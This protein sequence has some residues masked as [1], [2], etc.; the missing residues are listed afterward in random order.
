M[1]NFIVIS[2]LILVGAFSGCSK[3]ESRLDEVI[4]VRHRGADMPA[5]VHGNAEDKVFI[6]V[7]HG[8]G[9]FGLAF[10]D[11]AIKDVLEEAYV[12]VYWD[13]RG[14]GMSQGR[15]PKPDDLVSLMADDVIALAEVLRAKYGQDI[16]LFLMG[17]SWGGALGT[18]ALLKEDRQNLF[19]GWIAVDG[20]H[21]F[22]LAA[23]S[24]RGQMLS[25]AQEQIALGNYTDKWQ[26][27]HDGVS[28]L[29]SLSSDDYYPTLAFA[30]K[31][32]KLLYETGV[33]EHSLSSEK[34][35]RTIIDNN[36]VTWMTSNLLN[37]PVND[38]LAED[39]SLS[40][41]LTEITLPVLLIYGKYD[42][43]VPP[44]MGR[45]AYERLGSAEKELMIFEHSIHHPHDTEPDRFT[46][47]V[48]RFVEKYR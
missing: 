27:L 31:T 6:V 32:M 16:Q 28:E 44:V 41:R 1:R 34:V 37:Q 48:V 36:P 4:H 21:D 10:R 46:D 26:E 13:Q 20:V 39:Y 40:D 15:Y 30:A 35:Y 45:D 33:I 11:G 22:P 17:H 9:S 2:C 24:R 23:E 29:D 7:L 19:S 3:T 12:M 8:A 5:Y 38:A 14:Q 25:I 42:V 43:S 47:E 18:T